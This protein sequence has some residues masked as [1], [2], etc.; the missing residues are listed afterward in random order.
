[1][2]RSYVKKICLFLIPMILCTSFVTGTVFAGTDES[3]DAITDAVYLMDEMWAYNTPLGAEGKTIPSGWDVDTRGGQL[4]GKYS[5]SMTIKTNSSEYPFVMSKGIRPVGNG[6][7][8]YET[9]FSVSSLRDGVKFGILAGEQEPIYF[10]LKGSTVMLTTNAGNSLNLGVCTPNTAVGVKIEIDLDKNKG[11]IYYNGENRGN[12]EFERDAEINGTEIYAPPKSQI[13]IVVNYIKIYTNYLVNEIFS[14]GGPQNLPEDWTFD[15]TTGGGVKIVA[16]NGSRQNEKYSLKLVDSTVTERP[17]AYKFFD[18]ASGRV[19]CEFKTQIKDMSE[20]ASYVLGAGKTP[21][22]TVEIDDGC[23]WFNGKKNYKYTDNIWYTIRIE[24]DTSSKIADIKINGRYMEKQL[25]FASNKDYFDSFSFAAAYNSRGE[26]LLDDIKIWKEGDLPSDYPE[27]PIVPK[28]VK[29]VNIGMTTCSLWREGY[30]LGW[31]LI[32]AYKDERKPYLGWYD[33][34]NPEVADWEIKWMA[35]S[36]VDYQSFCWYLPHGGYDAGIK[37]PILYNALHDGYFNAKYSDAMKYSIIWENAGTTVTSEAFRNTI[38]PYWVEYYLKDDRYMR[39]DNKA[40]IGIYKV[41]AL[42]KSFGSVEKV[43]EELEY[44]RKVCRGLGYNDAILVTYE[45]G[46][47]AK[48]L[49]QIADSG[50]DG[51]TAYSWGTDAGIGGAEL[52]YNKLTTQASKGLVNVIPTASMGWDDEAWRNTNQAMEYLTPCEFENM[53]RLCTDKYLS[54]MEQT[55]S[56]SK[57]LTLDTWNEYGEG[58]FIM[59]TDLYGFGYLDAVRKVFTNSQPIER[60]RPSDKAVS[61]MGYL[62]NPDRIIFKSFLQYSVPGSEQ[63]VA[64]GNVVK[65]WNFSRNEDASQW[66]VEKQIENFQTENGVLK[67]TSV[68]TDPSIKLN[69]LSIKAT[70]ANYMLVKMKLDSEDNVANLYFITDVN[71]T[72]SQDRCISFTV[73]KSGMNEYAINLTS[74]IWKDTVKALRLD[75]MRSTGNFEIE[76]IKLIKYFDGDN[77]DV[78]IDGADY[79]KKRRLHVKNNITY[80]PLDELLF[81]VGAITEFDGMTAK[82]TY[83][84]KMIEVVPTMEW[85]DPFIPLR[86]TFEKLGFSVEF[87]SE[88]SKIQ[89]I[90]PPIPIK[91]TAQN[92]TVNPSKENHWEFNTNGNFEKWFVGKDSTISVEDGFLKADATGTDPQLDIVNLNISAKYISQ[93]A[94]GMKN[95]SSLTTAQMYFTTDTSKSYSADKV[96]NIRISPNDTEVKEYVVNMSDCL[97]W[98]G[99]ITGLRFDYL[100]GLGSVMIDYIR[101]LE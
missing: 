25:P 70:D 26:F 16:L 31:D 4:S 55:L 99:K 66:V 74:T 15:D 19:I 85:G 27:R 56:T 71:P 41:D 33:E 20:G 23:F 24:A 80:M 8:T 94:I 48:I 53:L 95:L 6:K 63:L 75:P 58:H 46:A 82:I 101:V 60:Q 81:A 18:K 92:I 61:R 7:V 84:D 10:S 100:T 64:E 34:G 65:E 72:W 44:L 17:A 13:N 79:S 9:S 29:D 30:H 98:N 37:E 69:E 88:K 77:P 86:D 76:S 59:P 90:A 47:D 39:V 93:I 96:V 43:K 22:V 35:E 45:R 87:D 38:I 42:I 57:M 73:D 89:L 14:T 28:K 68:G 49:G 54:S 67:G 52:Q 21:L 3:Y 62:Y 83:R 40:V 51:V 91:V 1:M 2:F 32:N 36:G 50:F 97:L 11:T 78:M 5:N 12:F